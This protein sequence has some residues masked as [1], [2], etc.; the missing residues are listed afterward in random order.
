MVNGFLPLVPCALPMTQPSRPDFRSLLTSQRPVHMA[1][2]SLGSALAVEIAAEA[3]WGA[4]LI[5][6]QHGAS[7]P[8]EL[9]ACLT[10]AR[11]ACTPAIVRVAS[12]DENLIGLALDAGAQGVMAP[13]IETAEQAVALVR[14]TKYPPIGRRSFGPYRGRYLIEGDYFSAANSWTIACGQIETE[15]GISNID[16][17]CSV[18]GLD[19]ICVG[20]NDL[21]IA[22]SRGA[23]RN[24]R[25]PAV[26]AAINHVHVKATDKG[27]ITAIFANDR[28]YAMDMATHGWQVISIGTDVAWISDMAK[29]L[30]MR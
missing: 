22:L 18:P 23:N 16:A 5:D 17:I 21:A 2:H 6:Q 1:W 12:L 13:M 20:P 30:L 19:M 14:A 28:E 25:A 7:G 15:F 4:A 11:A 9:I 26:L 8:A 3:G 27:L 29:N 24:I 10:A